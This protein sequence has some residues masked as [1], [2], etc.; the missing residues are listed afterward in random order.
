[1]SK[2]VAGVCDR[3]KEEKNLATVIEPPLQFSPC[4]NLGAETDTRCFAARNAILT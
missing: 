2:T 1:M 4:L 3:R